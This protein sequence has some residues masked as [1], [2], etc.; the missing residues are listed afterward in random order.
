M[1][2]RKTCNI[3]NNTT[4]YQVANT[5]TVELIN[6]NNSKSSTSTDQ[7]HNNEGIKTNNTADN[8]SKKTI[9][10]GTGPDT[11]IVP[12]KRSRPCPFCKLLEHT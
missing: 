10:N 1:A 9:Y 3:S 5:E 8:T 7:D 11:T 4:I 6:I 12:K 2:T